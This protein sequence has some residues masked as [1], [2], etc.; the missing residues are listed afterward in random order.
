MAVILDF[1]FVFGTPFFLL[2]YFWLTLYLAEQQS[3]HTAR[4]VR[5]HFLGLNLS[6]LCHLRFA[7]FD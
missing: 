5:H 7:S 2:V 3:Q 4:H 6:L 1:V